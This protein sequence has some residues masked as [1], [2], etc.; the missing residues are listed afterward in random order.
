MTIHKLVRSIE[1][2]VCVCGTLEIKSG[3]SPKIFRYHLRVVDSD[4]IPIPIQILE[5]ILQLMR[6]QAFMDPPTA[7]ELVRQIEER[8][9]LMTT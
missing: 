6:I 7:D 8:S 1:I 9:S 3:W 5:R 2:D 4:V